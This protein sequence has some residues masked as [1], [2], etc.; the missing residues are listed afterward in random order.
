MGGVGDVLAWVACLRGQCASVDGMLRWV[1]C[2]WV[3]VAV[4][5]VLK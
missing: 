2:F 4:G 5:G 3:V 1:T